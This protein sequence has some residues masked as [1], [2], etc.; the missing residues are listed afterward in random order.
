MESFVYLLRSRFLEHD[1][2][3]KHL[4]KHE[5]KSGVFLEQIEPLLIATST[6]NIIILR[7]YGKCR[8][9]GHLL[10]GRIIFVLDNLVS[11]LF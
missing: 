2:L 5:Y 8:R 4:Y 3:Y 1:R 9:D 6:V 10:S 11:F 7:L